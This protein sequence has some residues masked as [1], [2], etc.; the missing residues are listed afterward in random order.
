MP[1]RDDIEKLG[2]R[3]DPDFG[4][5]D[6]ALFDEF[7]LALNRGEVRAAER[8]S[9]GTWIVNA[10]VKQG[11]LLGFRM[12]Q[13]VDMSASSVLRFFDK[14]TYRT[15]PT[16]LSENIRIVPGGSSIREGAYLAP[17]VVC[18]P[19][20]YVNVGAYV[21]EGTMIDSHALVGSCAQIGKRVHLSA[22]AQIGGV[23]E[24]V[25]AVPVIIE[26]DVLVG[27]GC[28]VYEGTI[29]RAR[30]VLAAGTILTASTPV[31]DLAREKIYQRTAAAPL[32]IPAGAVVVPGS[33]EVR[34]ERGQAWGLSLYAPVIVKYRD[35]KTERAVQ[36]EDYLR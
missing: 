16:T 34:S 5:D 18:M 23:L 30:A 19:P 4:S 11:I 6:R 10:W 2:A 1:L 15:R 35:E 17:G 33:R 7:K 26:D 21:D 12:G 24:P 3:D 22:A 27:G 25:G 20:M 32:E 14:E 36:L 28:G 31:Y 8:T 13:L 9:D 29:V